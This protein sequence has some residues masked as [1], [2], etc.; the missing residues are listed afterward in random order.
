[1]GSAGPPRCHEVVLW[2]TPIVAR[3]HECAVIPAESRPPSKIT[4][5]GFNICQGLNI[6]FRWGRCGHVGLSVVC[7]GPV[8]HLYVGPNMFVHCG[9]CSKCSEFGTIILRD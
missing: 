7:G 4:Q 5:R 2:R 3:N 6:Y 8:A 9:G 1:M